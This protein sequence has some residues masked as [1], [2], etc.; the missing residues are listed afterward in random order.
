MYIERFDTGVDPKEEFGNKKEEQQASIG[1]RETR[2]GDPRTGDLGIVSPAVC[3]GRDA[4][5]SVRRQSDGIWVGVIWH[6][7]LRPCTGAAPRLV[8]ILSVGPSLDA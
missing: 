7:Q 1:T 6:Q 8:P 3:S 2:T 5:P 4:M